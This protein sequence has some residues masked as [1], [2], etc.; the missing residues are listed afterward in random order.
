MINEPP[1]QEITPPTL[2]I[3]I[4]LEEIKEKVK[5]SIYVP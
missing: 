1:R 4:L 5:L 3:K 2:S